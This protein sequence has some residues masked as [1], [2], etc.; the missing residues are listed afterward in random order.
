MTDIEKN[1][2]FTALGW[3]GQQENKGNMGFKDKEFD[4]LMR[5]VGFKDTQAWCAYFAKLVWLTAHVQAPKETRKMINAIM[6]GGSVASYNSFVNSDFLVNETAKEGA[7]VYWQKYRNGK[8]TWMGHAGI[9]VQVFDNSFVSV[10]GNTNP[11]G[12]REGYI[13]AKQG[14]R[15]NFHTTNGLRLLGFVHPEMKDENNTI[16]I[17]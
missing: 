5:A 9:V 4:E 8:A 11:N 3:V 6:N 1:I 12:G 13:V 7:A 16:V 14:R 17:S 10:E 2:V 15:M